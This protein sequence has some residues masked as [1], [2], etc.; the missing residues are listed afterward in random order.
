MKNRKTP[1]PPASSAQGKS[2]E[3]TR[4]RIAQV[5]SRVAIQCLPLARNDRERCELEAVSAL[6]YN[7]HATVLKKPFYLADKRRKSGG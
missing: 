3:P 2:T 1:K 4:S 6:L 5:F 7:G